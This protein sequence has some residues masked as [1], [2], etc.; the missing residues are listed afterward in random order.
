VASC[1]ADEEEKVFSLRL[2]RAPCSPKPGGDGCWRS[3][4]GRH[5][6]WERLLGQAHGLTGDDAYLYL[7]LN[8]LQDERRWAALAISRATG[9]LAWELT[10]R[11]MIPDLTLAGPVLVVELKNQVL[12]LETSSAAG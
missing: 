1:L 10:A 9:E 6:P 4:R 11:R 12:A 3:I 5:D 8:L 7:R 2:D